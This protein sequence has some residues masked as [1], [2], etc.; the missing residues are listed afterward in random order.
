M[1]V[2]EFIKFKIAKEITVVT[3]L[4]TY[5]HSG[6]VSFNEYN[7]TLN[8]KEIT[9][10]EDRIFTTVTSYKIESLLSFQIIVQESHKPVK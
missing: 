6:N 7:K 2:N 4:N 3:V 10:V 5:R 8:I 1:F 9:E